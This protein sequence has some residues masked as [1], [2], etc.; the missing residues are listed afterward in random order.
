[1][2]RIPWEHFVGVLGLALLLV[3]TWMGLF[4]AP[5]DAMQKDVQRIMYVHVPVAWASMLAL[6][7]VFVAALGWLFR[8]KWHWDALLEASNEVGVV[9]GAL[10]LATGAIWAKPVWNTWWTWD[11]RLTTAAVMLLAFSGL[12]ALRGFVD[13]PEKRASWSAVA[14]IIAYVDVP[15]VYFSVRWWRSI[16]QV[17]STKGTMNPDMADTLTVMSIAFVLVATWFVARRYR[18]ARARLTAEMEEAA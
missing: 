6:T 17:Q 8:G 18:I 1:M 14:A 5:E 9:L 11:P 16:H 2:R 3:G 12:I 7:V 10:L 13:D 15:I 4:W